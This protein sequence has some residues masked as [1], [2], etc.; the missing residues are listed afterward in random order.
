MKKLVTALLCLVMVF[1]VPSVALAH[2]Q[3]QSRAIVEKVGVEA[4]YG[5]TQRKAFHTLCWEESRYSDTAK[6]GKHYGLFQLGFS[7]VPF[8]LWSDPT[9]NSRKAVVYISHRYH[10]KPTEALSHKHTYGWY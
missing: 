9:W 8:S 7:S 6:S 2:T 1:A 5:A 4:H 3:Y 10:G